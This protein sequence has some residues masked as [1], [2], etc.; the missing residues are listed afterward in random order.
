MHV[1]EKEEVAAGLDAR[2]EQEAAAAGV[3]GIEEAHGTKAHELVQEG[4]VDK[5][6][7]VE[8]RNQGD[9]DEGPGSPYREFLTVPLRTRGPGPRRDDRESWNWK[10]R[11]S[12][13]VR[14]GHESVYEQRTACDPWSPASEEW[15]RNSKT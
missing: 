5:P 11:R 8:R 13:D 10:C 9:E 14:E 2:K 12:V 4:L 1:K 3:L 15:K 6:E 7:V